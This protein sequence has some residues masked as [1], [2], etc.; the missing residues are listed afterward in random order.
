MI[1]IILSSLALAAA[2]GCVVL[3]TLE[4][5]RSRER[6]AADLK[7]LRDAGRMIGERIKKQDAEWC[8]RT[9]RMNALWTETVGGME[10]RIKALE[11]GTV[12]D[13]EKAREAAKAVDEF[14]QGLANILNYD[15]YEL[16]KKNREGED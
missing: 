11:D 5:K 7:F 10:A 1:G 8:E 6:N 12:P 14:H 2:L 13:Y 9:E 16:A 3:V 4:G 15:P